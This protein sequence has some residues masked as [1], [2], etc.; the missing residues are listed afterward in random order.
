MALAPAMT[1]PRFRTVSETIGSSVASVV[2]ATTSMPR[3]ITIARAVYFAAT[4]SVYSDGCSAR[5]GM[6]GVPPNHF[7]SDVFSVEAVGSGNVF[8]LLHQSWI[9]VVILSG[10]VVLR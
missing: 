2:P 10:F 6:A 8:D 1:L 3:F 9:V 4:E 5:L 7:R